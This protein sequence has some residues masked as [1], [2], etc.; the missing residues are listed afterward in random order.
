M[1]RSGHITRPGG[2]KGRPGD[3]GV[4][5]TPTA[6]WVTGSGHGEGPLGVSV[7]GALPDRRPYAPDGSGTGGRSDG[8]APPRH[9]AATSGGTSRGRDG[10][11]PTL[12]VLR[13]AASS[14]A[15]R[16][17]APPRWS[18]VLPPVPTP[19]VPLRRAPAEAGLPAV[20]GASVE[21]VGRVLDPPRGRP[22]GLPA[23][24]SRPPPGAHVVHSVTCR[25]M[26]CSQG[27]AQNLWMT[28]RCRVGPGQVRRACRRDA[29]A[30]RS[31]VH[32][33]RPLGVSV[34]GASPRPRGLAAPVRRARRAGGAPRRAGSTAPG[35]SP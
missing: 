14:S 29:G 5:T 7:R 3:A 23:A 12:G 2:P 6:L 34:R 30:A 17:V 9:P 8:A 13:A 21:V 35:S 18:V 28:A 27:C 15:A 25:I 19:P 1:D 24:N 4:W 11:D 16:R 33:S 32:G 31:V 20:D 26:R 22:Q 10:D